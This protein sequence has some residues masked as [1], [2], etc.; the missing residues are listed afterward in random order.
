MNKIKL[1]VSDLDGT[2]LD[3]HEQLPKNWSI[4]FQQCQEKGILFSAASGRQLLNME[5]SFPNDKD[6][7]LFIAENGT[8]IKYN[9]EILYKSTL[10]QTKISNLIKNARTIKNCWAVYCADDRGYIDS[11]DSHLV[12]ECNKYFSKL[13]IVD[14]LLDVKDECCKVAIYK[15][16]GVEGDCLESFKQ[17][18]DEFDITVSAH[19]W[20]TICNKNESKGNALKLF[21]EK[22]NISK[23]E[24]M[25]FGDYLNDVSLM[26][27]AY[28]SYAMENAH[29]ELKKHARF[30]APSN[31][32]GGVMQVVEEMLKSQ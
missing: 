19:V 32:E 3:C 31:N 14:D 30:I 11:K 5:S 9:N 22:F 15:T 16:D 6:K 23:E 2:L 26:D 18:S 24:T 25:V 8:C 28:Y 27:C 12:E 20:L 1:I 21:Q 4:V 29:P 7:M 17:Y 13:E 10:N